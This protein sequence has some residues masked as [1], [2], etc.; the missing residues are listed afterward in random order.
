MALQKPSPP[1]QARETGLNPRLLAGG[2]W[3][4]TSLVETEFIYYTRTVDLSSR[5]VVN[6]RGNITPLRNV[7]QANP[8]DRGK[9]L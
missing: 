8:R 7:Q 4:T 6:Q 9:N 1:L 5:A 2:S 3:R